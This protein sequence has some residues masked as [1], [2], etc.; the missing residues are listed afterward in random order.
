MFKPLRASL[1]VLVVLQVACSALHE[2]IGSISVSP[3]GKF[4]AVA[5]EKKGTSFIY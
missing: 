1:L 5:Y 4:L 3:D 2:R